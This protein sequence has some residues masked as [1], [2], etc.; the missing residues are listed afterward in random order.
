MTM[1]HRILPEIR[2]AQLRQTLASGMLVRAIEAHNGVSALVS[3][4]MTSADNG[5]GG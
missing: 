3:S 2:R 4:E 5:D 1:A